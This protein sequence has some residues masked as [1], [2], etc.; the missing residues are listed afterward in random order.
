MLSPLDNC[1]RMPHYPD[2]RRQDF[3]VPV[4]EQMLA[5]CP[6]LFYSVNYYA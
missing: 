5:V 1:A 2:Q 6:V 4:D 3:Y